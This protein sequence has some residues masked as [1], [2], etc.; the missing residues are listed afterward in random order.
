M[1]SALLNRLNLYPHAAHA[2]LGLI[3]VAH[4]LTLW[5]AL[6]ASWLEWMIAVACWFITGS[7]GMAIGFHRLLSHGLQTSDRCRRFLIWCGCHAMTGPPISWVAIHRAHHRYSDTPLDPH[8]PE[9]KG[10]AWVQLFS[11]YHKPSIKYAKDMIRDPYLTQW[12][13]HYFSYH[14][15]LIVTGIVL[16]MATGSMVWLALHAVPAVL[17]WHT[18]SLVNSFGHSEHGAKDSH[19]ISMLSW[20]EGYHQLHHQ[21]PKAHVFLGKN[22]PFDVSGLVIKGFINKDAR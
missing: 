4:V 9:H 20:G 1:T 8:G 16:T 19:F 14:M 7:L 18:G 10:K 3:A 15:A 6:N 12:Q 13:K 22:A 5:F 17:T 2:L 11:M 21:N